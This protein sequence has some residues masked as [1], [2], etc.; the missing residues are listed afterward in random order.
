[1]TTFGDLR[2]QRDRAQRRNTSLVVIL[3]F[4]IMV[5]VVEEQRLNQSLDA[6]GQGWHETMGALDQCLETWPC[7]EKAP[8]PGDTPKR[9]R[10]V[11]GEPPVPDPPGENIKGTNQGHSWGGN[12]EKN[13]RY[14]L[15]IEQ[16]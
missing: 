13:T 2:K 8:L 3:I 16:T 10:Q 5:F 7:P 11:P 15:D 1:M 4:V 12:F 9:P 14:H 6:C